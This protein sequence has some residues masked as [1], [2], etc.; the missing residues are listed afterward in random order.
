MRFVELHGERLCRVEVEPGRNLL[1]HARDSFR[2]IGQALAVRILSNGDEQLRDGSLR[3]LNV[4]AQMPYSSC[5]IGLQSSPIVQSSPNRRATASRV[6]A[7]VSGARL[8]SISAI[9]GVF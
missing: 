8:V 2:R 6:G 7:A 9:C 5:F 3:P 4:N 1:V